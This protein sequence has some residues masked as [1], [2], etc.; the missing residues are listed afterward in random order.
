M[1]AERRLK[2]K[3]RHNCFKVDGIRI[4]YSLD[5]K[6]VTHSES[7]GNEQVISVEKLLKLEEELF[8]K[9]WRLND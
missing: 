1:T 5:R 6:E 8:D 4:T 9:F 7:F 3:R 2:E